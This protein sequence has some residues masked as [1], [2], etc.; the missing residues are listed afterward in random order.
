MMGQR[1]RVA[2]RLQDYL[3]PPRRLDKD[4]TYNEQ[5]LLHMRLLSTLTFCVF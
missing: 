2:I 3:A 5:M 4:K 1:E